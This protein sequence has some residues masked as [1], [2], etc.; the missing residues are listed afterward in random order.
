MSAKA[1]KKI[2]SFTFADK[3]DYNSIQLVSSAR[4]TI[5]TTH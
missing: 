1:S 3:M 5:D 2:A 4:Y